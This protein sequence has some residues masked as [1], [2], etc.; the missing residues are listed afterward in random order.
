M[1]AR[2]DSNGNVVEFPVYIIDGFP[3]IGG[4]YSG[5]LP[6]DIVEVDVYTNKPSTTWNQ[7]L[8]YSDIE[9]LN[10][11]YILNYDTTTKFI[12]FESK[13]SYIRDL[14][15]IYRK[16]NESKFTTMAE[17]VNGIYKQPEINTW[18][19]QV[20]EAK[21]YINNV[22][23]YPLLTKLAEKR[24][25]TISEMVDNV[26]QKYEAHTLA[27]GEVLGTYQKNRDL[28]DSIDL[29]DETTFDLIDSYGW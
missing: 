26:M 23:D 25:I 11:Q 14:V 16:N 27:Y 17:Q 24:G 19:L 3:I 10:G 21:N 20:T 9:I 5:D 28:L 29:D 4:G 2:I 1:Y 7:A 6:E 8:T 13:Q 18:F 22:N 12:D 15:R